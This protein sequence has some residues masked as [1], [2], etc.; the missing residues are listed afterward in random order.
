MAERLFLDIVGVGK[1][2]LV[3][4]VCDILQEKGMLVQGFYTQE[5][6]EH[7]MRTGFDVIT[8]DGQQGPLAR[9]R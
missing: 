9:L 8:L 7:G 2:T 5:R 3:Q 1:T 6:R 4:K